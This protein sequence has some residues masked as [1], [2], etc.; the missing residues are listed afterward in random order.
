MKSPV[1]SLLGLLMLVVPASAET[2][3]HRHHH[4]HRHV[5]GTHARHGEA[6]FPITAAK[7]S[8]RIN[9]VGEVISQPVPVIRK[10]RN[11][12]NRAKQDLSKPQPQPAPANPA[13]QP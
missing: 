10:E 13:P 2:A 1:L 4:R 5:V 6:G 3:R 12:D 11:F 9:S 7:D 8:I